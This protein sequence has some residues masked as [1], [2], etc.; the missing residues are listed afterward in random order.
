MNFFGLCLNLFLS[1]YL[2][3]QRSRPFS[4]NLPLF[5][6]SF[7]SRKHDYNTNADPKLAKISQIVIY[8]DARHMATFYVCKYQPLEN[9]LAVAL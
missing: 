3:E 4:H 1:L 7:L 9:P 8:D 6:E 2:K 5:S